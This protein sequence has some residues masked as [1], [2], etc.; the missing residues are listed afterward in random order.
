MCGTHVAVVSTIGLVVKL[1]RPRV[2]GV[3]QSVSANCKGSE[4]SLTVGANEN[5]NGEECG[6]K[7]GVQC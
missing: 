7:S 5:E 6:S 2:A 4:R 1:L 3:A